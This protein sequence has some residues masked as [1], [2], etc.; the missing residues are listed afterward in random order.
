MPDAAPRYYLLNGERHLSVGANDRKTIRLA[1]P[2]NVDVLCEFLPLF[3]RAAEAN[4]FKR[5]TVVERHALYLFE[6]CG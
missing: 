2:K 4:D 3:A 5:V 6:A 1:S